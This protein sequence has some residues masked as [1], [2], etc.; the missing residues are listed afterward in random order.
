MAVNGEVRGTAGHDEV[1]RAP[2]VIQGGT[3]RDIDSG[4]IDSVTTRANRVR[5]VALHTLEVQAKTVLGNG[6]A[7]IGVGRRTDWQADVDRC[8]PRA[9]LL[10]H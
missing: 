3:L 10:C 8:G 6:R 9:E 2:R 5:R 4:D 1:W 7:E